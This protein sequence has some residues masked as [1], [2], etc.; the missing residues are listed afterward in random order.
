MK[1]FM[2]VVF[3]AMAMS[4]MACGNKTAQTEAADSTAVDTTVVDSIEGSD[5]IVAD[6]VCND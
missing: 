4:F 2:Y 6:S 5:S 3:A 1:K